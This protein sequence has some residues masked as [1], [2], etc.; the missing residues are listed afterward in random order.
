MKTKLGRPEMPEGK[1]NT[2]IINLRVS[3]EI[4]KEVDGAAKQSKQKKPEW[5]RNALRKE[6]RNSPVW[7]NRNGSL[8]NWTAKLLN[9]S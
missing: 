6:A 3:G 1:A 5:M 9:S 4:L 7:V 8:R 2:E